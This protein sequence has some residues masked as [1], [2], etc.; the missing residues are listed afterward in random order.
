MIR[1]KDDDDHDD[2]FSIDME[3]LTARQHAQYDPPFALRQVVK[4]IDRKS[5]IAGRMKAWTLR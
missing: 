3:F 5:S 1:I 2:Y 4:L